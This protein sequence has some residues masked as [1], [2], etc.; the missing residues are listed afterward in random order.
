MVKETNSAPKG[1][2]GKNMGINGIKIGRPATDTKSVNGILCLLDNCGFPIPGLPAILTPKFMASQIQNGEILTIENSSAVIG[3]ATVYKIE[4]PNESGLFTLIF[5]QRTISEPETMATAIRLFREYYQKRGLTKITVL[6][7]NT[8]EITGKTLMAN[9]FK[10][11]TPLQS[12]LKVPGG[13]RDLRRLTTTANGREIK[14]LSIS[15]SILEKDQKIEKL[16]IVIKELQK[17]LAAAEKMNQ[18]IT[19]NLSP[20]ISEFREKIISL[21]KELDNANKEKEKYKEWLDGKNNQ[22]KIAEEKIRLLETGLKKPEKTVTASSE[23]NQPK[24]GKNERIILELVTRHLDGI[25]QQQIIKE[26]GI[27]QSEVSKSVRSLAE[28]KLVTNKKFGKERLV[29]LVLEEVE[30]PEAE[31]ESELEIKQRVESALETLHKPEVSLT[32]GLSL[33][34]LGIGQ[35]KAERFVEAVRAT[36]LCHIIGSPKDSE[37]CFIRLKKI[38][39]SRN[40]SVDEKTEPDP[41]TPTETQTAVIPIEEFLEGEKKR[42]RAYFSTLPK[43]T[44]AKEEISEALKSGKP[45]KAEI[46]G[47]QYGIK[48]S[49]ISTVITLLCKEINAD[50][51]EGGKPLVKEIKIKETPDYANTSVEIIAAMGISEQKITED[52][53]EAKKPVATE[54]A[55]KASEKILAKLSQTHREIFYA[56]K[57]KGGNSTKTAIKNEVGISKDVLELCISTLVENGLVTTEPS[58]EKVSLNNAA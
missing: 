46:F 55:L 19:A 43:F 48:K 32:K 36:G 20:E 37:N 9:E 29:K 17:Q 2:G 53:E 34:E 8:D 49:E 24:L 54:P 23:N 11:E 40:K 5:D 25:K 45:I 22:L 35:E 13:F 4:E 33:K 3:A 15:A 58:S 52:K 51:K 28:K 7:P 14:P 41:P 27:V 12:Q 57:E 10:E 39:L 1:A 18:E 44:R 26:T 47:S 6:L 50:N 21:Q 38:D 16:G 30:K 56:I 31:P 42:L